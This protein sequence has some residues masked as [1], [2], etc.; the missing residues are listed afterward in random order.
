MALSSSSILFLTL[1]LSLSQKI[2][3]LAYTGFF[4][5]SVKKTPAKRNPDSTDK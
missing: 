4:Q 5:V 3:L 1:T 2:V